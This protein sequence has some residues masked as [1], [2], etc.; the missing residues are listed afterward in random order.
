MSSERDREEALRSTLEQSHRVLDPPTPSF[1]RVWNRAV[2]SH[3]SAKSPQHR[4]SQA[5]RWAIAAGLCFAV[6]LPLVKAFL[7]LAFP[8][9]GSSGRD[10]AM[11]EQEALHFAEELGDWASPLEFLDQAPGADLFS[12]FP[13]FYPVF[14]GLEEFSFD[15]YPSIS[16]RGDRSVGTPLPPA[17]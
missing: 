9:L 6:A 15:D 7:P 1:E 8:N 4:R 13:E 2:E 14:P 10:I 16:G 11:T 3:R 12:S 5:L 17:A